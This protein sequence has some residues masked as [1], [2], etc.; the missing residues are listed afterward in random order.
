M[1]EVWALQWLIRKIDF[2]K[3]HECRWLG[4]LS[5]ALVR[6][7]MYSEIPCS[8]SYVVLSDMICLVLQERRPCGNIMCMGCPL[9]LDQL[10]I[11]WY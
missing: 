8:E 7:F 9:V 6:F 4:V 1:T 5:Y 10:T 11:Y 3:P 2:R